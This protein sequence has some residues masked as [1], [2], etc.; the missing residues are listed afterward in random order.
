[1]L[2]GRAGACGSVEI[3]LVGATYFLVWLEAFEER[4]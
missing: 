1:M 2:R 3:G 4:E